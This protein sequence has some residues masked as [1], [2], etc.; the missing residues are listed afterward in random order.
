[1][2]YGLFREG[3]LGTIEELDL[4]ILIDQALRNLP[5]LQ[6]IIIQAVY[7]EEKTVRE[8]AKEL[9]M[10]KSEVDRQKQAAVIKLKEKIKR[11]DII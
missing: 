4:Q 5:R 8:I 2:D 11:E 9:N 7:F 6:A 10:S 3:S 1:M